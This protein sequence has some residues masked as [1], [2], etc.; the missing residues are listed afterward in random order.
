MVAGPQLH[1]ALLYIRPIGGHIIQTPST[2]GS[3]GGCYRHRAAA[4]WSSPKKSQWM[5]CLIQKPWGVEMNAPR[6]REY[7]S[8]QRLSTTETALLEI[9]GSGL[10]TSCF[11]GIVRSPC[12]G[13]DFVQ[14]LS[15]LLKTQ[16][17]F[18][19]NEGSALLLFLCK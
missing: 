10:C 9:L 5:S 11:P 17:S 12:L 16:D 6:G 19:L 13:S 1:L 8:T 2:A 15:G 4:S 14:L 7:V 3:K 18:L